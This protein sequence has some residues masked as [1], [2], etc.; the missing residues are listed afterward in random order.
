MVAIIRFLGTNCERDM[1][2]VYHDLLEQECAYIWYQESALPADTKLVILPGGFSYG[3]YLRSGAIAS[4]API[5]R[6]IKAFGEKGGYVLGICN[7]FQ[8][9][10]ESKLLPGALMRNESLHFISKQQKLVIQNTENAF[11]KGYVSNESITLPIAHAD[12]NYF[13]TPSTLEAL[14]ENGQILLTYEDN[15]NGS[16][17]NIAGIC[18]QEKNIFGL[19][20]HPER[21]SEAILGNTQ[22][23][24]MLKNLCR[25]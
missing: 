10:T 16:L 12:G 15:P 11:L 8:I 3:D 20:P 9:L 2:Y 23:L 22:G 4:S 19:M 14:K 18:N 7:G 24:K 21:A 13:A 6:A 25:L 1:H 5:M 17:E